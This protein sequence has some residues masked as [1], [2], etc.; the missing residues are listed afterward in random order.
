[1]ISI[2][3]YFKILSGIFF[4]ILTP[5][6]FSQSQKGTSIYGEAAD[7]ASGLSVSMPDNNTVA[8]GATGNDESGIYAGH[9]RI[10]RWNGDEWLQKGN[11]IDGEAP[12]DFSGKSVSMPD[13]NIVAI[14]AINNNGTGSKAGH[15][16][17]YRWNGNAWLQ[18][19]DDIDGEAADDNSGC[20][21]SMPDSNTVAIGAMDNDSSAGHVRI[22]SWNGTAWLQKGGDIDGEAADD[23]SGYSVSMPDINTVAIGAY[24]NDGAGSMAG[25][26]RIFNWDGS[27]WLQ[28]G[29]DIDGEAAGDKSGFSVCMPDSITVAVGAP[30]NDDGGNMAG[31]V[32][33]Y[34][35]N[36]TAWLQ[37]GNDI[38]GEQ[39]LETFGVSVNMPDSN[40]VA[41]SSTWRDGTKG[42]VGRVKIY[43]WNGSAW[44]QKGNNIIGE[45]ESDYL[46]SSISM[47]NSNVIA[48]GAHGYD[49]GGTDAGQVQVYWFSSSSTISPVVCDNYTSPSGINTWNSSG[50]YTDTIPNSAGY[51]SIITINLTVNT[52]DVS[53]TNSSPTLTANSTDAT[54]QWL[55]CDNN[56]T[57]ISGETSQSFTPTVNGNYA[58]EITRNQ[59]TD[60]SACET[61]SIVGIQE[62][63]FNDGFIVYPNPTKGSV[64]IELPES[65]KSF[66]VIIRN[67][68]GQEL[69]KQTFYSTNK[70][71]LSIPGRPGFY[72]IEITSGKENKTV[73]KIYKK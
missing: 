13:S 39:A 18:K 12:G 60:T 46:G 35:W 2:K 42:R 22:Y 1:M 31:H 11:D 14:G 64:R 48:I 51:D 4:M 47:P 34:R 44:L 71:E 33:I 52:V 17:I 23:F 40:I 27:D 5:N 45:E 6:V 61:V 32:R 65:Y 29:T 63:M 73:L 3:T 54:Y 28:K 70:L 21:V 37:K 66:R 59:C 67:A 49:G 38:D 58:V 36:G 15:V 50:T 10:Y 55:D 56:M 24:G 30:Y 9:V 26:V 8:I 16:R 43:Q 69:Q 7:D 68:L 41:V 25:H 62:N 57:T 20:S 19:G 72:F 53:V